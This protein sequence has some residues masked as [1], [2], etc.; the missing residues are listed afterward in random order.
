M[1]LFSAVEKRLPGAPII[2][3]DLGVFGEDVV[4][5]LEETGFPGMRVIQFGFD[6]GA[7]SFHL[8]HNYPQNCVAYVGTHDNNT[9]LGWLWGASDEERRFALRYCCFGGRNWGEGGPYS[10]SCRAVIEAVWRSSANT[11]IVAF[12]DM[13]GYGEDARMNR[14][15]TSK[16]NWTFR[17]V[18]S[19][20]DKL[21]SAYFKEINHIYR[22]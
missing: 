15:G 19:E 12:Q 13:M 10:G 6:P 11:A 16:N 1:K 21:D 7:D 4:R 20:L 8:P 22:R 5:L 3:E 2:A 17:T 14:P 18:Q 9:I